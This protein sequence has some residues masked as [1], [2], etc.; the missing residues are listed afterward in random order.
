MCVRV[1]G[2][3]RSNRRTAQGC[4]MRF[5]VGCRAQR[6]AGGGCT[7]QCI[8]YLKARMAAISNAPPPKVAL[9]IYYRGASNRQTKQSAPAS[10]RLRRI[11]QGA[12]NFRAPDKADASPITCC[13]D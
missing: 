1:P 7:N 5:G 9:T 12:R 8:A 13:W 6:F 2:P 11:S 3:M 4:A 10:E